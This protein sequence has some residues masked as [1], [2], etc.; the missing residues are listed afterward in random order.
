MVALGALSIGFLGVVALLNRSLRVSHVVSENYIAS[1]LASEGVE[2]IKNFIDTNDLQG[3]PWNEGIVGTWG[4]SYD[5]TTLT[6]SIEGA[7]ASLPLRFDDTRKVYNYLVGSPTPFKRSVKVDL[8][9]ALGH[10]VRVTSRVTWTT[11]GGGV[12]SIDVEDHFMR[13]EL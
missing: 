8:I 2:V 11:A 1:Y 6:P 5:S 10:E 3:A 7:R 12:F 4:V 13:K 9:D